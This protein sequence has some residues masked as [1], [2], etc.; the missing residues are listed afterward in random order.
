VEKAR[1]VGPFWCFYGVPKNCGSKQAGI[2][3]MFKWLLLA[4]FLGLLF[5]FWRQKQR[6]PKKHP[7]VESLVRCSVCGRHISVHSA[8]ISAKGHYRCTLHAGDP[9]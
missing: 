2:L 1:F 8:M 4:G 9:D 6:I 5:Y 7:E 3:W